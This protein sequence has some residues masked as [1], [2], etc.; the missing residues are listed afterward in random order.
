MNVYLGAAPIAAA[1]RDGAQV[2]VTG[3][4]A[5]PA[6][7][8]GPLV[9]HFGWDWDDLDRIAAGTLAGHLLEC[10]CQVSGGYFA[11][12]GMKDVPGMA[13]IGFP[14]AEVEAV[15]RASC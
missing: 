7:V 4:V 8:L 6:L 1:I 15:G 14:I 11:D 10:G 13:T 5:D 2:V 9:A 12:P 3:R